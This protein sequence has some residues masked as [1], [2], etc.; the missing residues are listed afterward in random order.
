[1][2]P[3]LAGVV[4]SEITVLNKFVVVVVVLVFVIVCSI[5]GVQKSEPPV[6][7]HNFVKS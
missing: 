3:V 5:Q 1:M 2:N 4:C 6:F 7:V